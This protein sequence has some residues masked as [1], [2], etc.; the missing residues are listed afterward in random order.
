[1]RAFNVARPRQRNIYQITSPTTCNLHPYRQASELRLNSFFIL[2]TLLSLEQ[3][4]HL[5]YFIW[6]RV[7]W[8]RDGFLVTSWLVG[9]FSV[10]K[11]PDTV[12]RDWDNK[13]PTH[14]IN[15]YLPFTRKSKRWKS[16]D[17]EIKRCENCTSRNLTYKFCTGTHFKNSPD[18]WHCRRRVHRRMYEIANMLKLKF[19]F[20][21]GWKGID[22]SIYEISVCTVSVCFNYSSSFSYD[23][24]SSSDLRIRLQRRDC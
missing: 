10:A 8:W 12:T 4:I 18:C 24:F 21:F 16:K 13:A 14:T 6:R 20:M 22:R 19:K 5:G 2:T 7:G 23:D 1:M 3:L 17:V 11:R 9:G 15:I